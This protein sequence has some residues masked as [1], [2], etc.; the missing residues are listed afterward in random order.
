[1]T[2]T[3]TILQTSITAVAGG[4]IFYYLALP[5]PWMLGPLT[6]VLVFKACGRE[7]IWPTPIRD[8]GVIVLGAMM[9]A[10]FTP[11]TVRQIIAQLPGM[12]LVTGVS[13]LFGY[14]AAVIT[15]NRTGISLTSSLL[16]STPGGLSQM[17]LICDEFEDA[18]LTAVS[19]LQTIRLLSVIFIVPFLA[20]HAVSD[21]PAVAVSSGAATG[22]E[23]GLNGI[24]GLY[25][26]SAIA[27]AVI[28]N[29]LSFPSPYML[30]PLL[31]VA[32]LGVAGF[33]LPRTPMY[34]SAPAQL[35]MGAFMGAGIDLVSLCRQKRL[36]IYALLGGLIVVASSLVSAWLLT[37]FYRVELNTAF[38]SA[39]PGGIAEMG[40]TAAMINADVSIVT[41]YQIFRMLFIVVA[42]PYFFRWW[43]KKPAAT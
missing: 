15:A 41:A 8:G 35:C 12:T 10:W 17:I 42:V 37:W 22:I 3:K 30:G 24:T 33:S 7:A 40:V 27:G 31:G 29:R 36:L 19:M 25:A 18:D 23:M 5:L 28:A 26:A 16:G 32:V 6:G 13:L 38:L 11:E 43:L 21:G 20:I 9:G 34:L 2:N 1:M 14:F 39:A 4:L